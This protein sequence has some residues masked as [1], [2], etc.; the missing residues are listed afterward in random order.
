MLV[1]S[2]VCASLAQYWNLSRLNE[3]TNY[4]CNDNI[5]V[6]SNGGY[7]SLPLSTKIFVSSIFDHSITECFISYESI[8]DSLD[9]LFSCI[10][11]STGWPKSFPCLPASYHIDV[12][13]VFPSWKHARGLK[14]SPSYTW[15]IADSLLFLYAR[16]ARTCNRRCQCSSML[17]ILCTAFGVPSRVIHTIRCSQ[18]PE[19]LFWLWTEKIKLLILS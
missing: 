15:W 12:H 17:N 7:E 13:E 2:Q 3:A 9:K 14:E 8:M 11:S 10:S 19:S 16:S 6:G 4:S 5:L 18:H 1:W